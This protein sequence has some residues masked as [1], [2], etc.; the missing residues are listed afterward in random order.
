MTHA[1]LVNDGLYGLLVFL[2][3]L[4]V[5]FVCAV[6]RMPPEPAC[7]R[8]ARAVGAPATPRPRVTTL[9]AG[10]A[11]QPGDASYPARH[12]ADPLPG[13]TVIRRPTVSSEPPWGGTKAARPDPLGS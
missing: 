10:T 7:A 2:T 3:L 11:G 12:A 13:Q 4:L 6:I 5:M 1:A 8:S 9:A